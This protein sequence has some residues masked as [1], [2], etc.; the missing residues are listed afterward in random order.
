MRITILLFFYL[1][2]VFNVIGQSVDV[3][4]I[5]KLKGN[6]TSVELSEWH[7]DKTKRAIYMVTYGLYVNVK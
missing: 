5:D 7:A 2:T 3:C 1:F 6:V 4:N